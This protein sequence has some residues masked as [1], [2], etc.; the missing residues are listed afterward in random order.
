MAMDFDNGRIV[1]GK[2]N[3]LSSY[4]SSLKSACG[5]NLLYID[6][7]NWARVKDCIENMQT[8]INETNGELKKVLNELNVISSEVEQV[9]DRG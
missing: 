3:Y 9:K 1:V 6:N 5:D 2:L 4:L 7:D 8:E